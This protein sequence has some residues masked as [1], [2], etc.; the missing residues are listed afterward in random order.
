MTIDVIMPSYNG[1]AYLGAQLDSIRHQSLV[2]GRV[3]IR[4]D[5][6]SDAT[7]L[8]LGRWAKDWSAIQVVEDEQQHLGVTAGFHRLFQVAAEQSDAKLIA[9]ADQD[10]VWLPEK[11]QR[12]A[13]WHAEQDDSLPALYCAGAMLADQNMKPLGNAPTWQRPLGLQ[14]ALVENVALGCTIVLNRPALDLLTGEWPSTVIA[15]DWWAY[16][17]VASHGGLLHYDPRPALNYRQHGRNA[18]G[19]LP[20]FAGR[21]KKRLGRFV[22]GDMPP[23]FAQAHGLLRSHG[24]AMTPERRQL[25]KAFLTRAEGVQRL[26]A[27]FNPV[28]QRQRLLDNLALRVLMATGAI[29]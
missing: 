20:S 27:L 11:L 4:D 18:I 8:M 25:V 15:H 29:K 5:G 7:R 16:L 14:N 3:F 22:G 23:L 24:E 12:A 10:D 19:Y 9:L 6:S 17:V 28:G 26:G 1:A 2:P 21:W 13:D